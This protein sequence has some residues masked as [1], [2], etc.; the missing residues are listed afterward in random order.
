MVYH[1]DPTY[2]LYLYDQSSWL[3]Y[4]NNVVVGYQY[5]TLSVSNVIIIKVVGYQYNN[6][7]SSHLASYCDAAG[8]QSNASHCDAYNNKF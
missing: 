8:L 6:V 7:F 2:I 1:G 5:Q 4:C 3:G